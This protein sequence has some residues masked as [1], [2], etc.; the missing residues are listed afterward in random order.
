MK[1]FNRLVSSDLA[2]NIHTQNKLSDAVYELLQ[3]DRSQHNIWAVMKQQQ[4]TLVTDHPILA[5]QLQYQQNNIRDHLNRKFLLQLK[6]TQIKI[7]PPKAMRKIIK[8]KR[9]VISDNTAD[10]LKTIAD[11]IDDDEVK[12]S[13]KK[14][15][16]KPD[17]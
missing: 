1:K 2:R 6:N 7:A 3:L 15:A 12:D 17:N 8:E 4:L 5:T 9:F 14:I 10:V 11:L 16:D 13:L